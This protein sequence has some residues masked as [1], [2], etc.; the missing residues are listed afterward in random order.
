M[1]RSNQPHGHEDAAKTKTEG[2][3]IQVSTLWKQNN[4]RNQKRLPTEKQRGQCTQLSYIRKL[5]H[6]SAK[7]WTPWDSCRGPGTVHVHASNDFIAN[8]SA[9]EIAPDPHDWLSS[10]VDTSNETPGNP[11]FLKSSFA[12]KPSLRLKSSLV[13]SLKKAWLCE[14]REL[15]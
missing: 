14:D 12:V 3:A 8:C 9:I 13:L 4:R 10:L 7:N 1:Q 2:T 5:G 6:L 11:Q 15:E